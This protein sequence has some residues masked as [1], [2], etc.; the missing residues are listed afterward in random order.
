MTP[1]ELAAQRLLMAL[2]LGCLLGL[3]YGF[4]RPLRRIGNWLRD[5]LFLGCLLWAWLL[6]GFGICGGDLRLGYFSGLFLGGVLWEKTVGKLLRPLFFGFWN[7]IFHVLSG[8]LWIFKKI[9]QKFAGF[10]K[11]HL[12]LKKNRVQ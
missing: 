6:L 11:K 4:L 2:V 8:F 3:C 5:L 1:P 12:H 10:A 9:F 7:G